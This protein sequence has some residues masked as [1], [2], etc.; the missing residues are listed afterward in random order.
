MCGKRVDTAEEST[1]FVSLRTV[2]GR[3]EDGG[4]RALPN[5]DLC[6]VCG[7]LAAILVASLLLLR[8]P[9]LMQL[10]RMRSNPLSDAHHSRLVDGNAKVFSVLHMHS[11]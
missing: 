5:T 4:I 2:A 3:L 10:P 9:K 1:G 11:F 6:I 7:C 8:L